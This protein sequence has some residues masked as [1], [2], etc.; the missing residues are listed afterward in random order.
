MT[1]FVMV[2][3]CELGLDW[4]RETETV[5]HIHMSSNKMSNP[6]LSMPALF[7]GLLGLFPAAELVSDAS[8]NESA[9]SAC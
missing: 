6:Y 5:T 3:T 4:M 8:L 1:S 9:S 7:L 2:V